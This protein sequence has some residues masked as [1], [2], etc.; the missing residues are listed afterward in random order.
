MS[1]QKLEKLYG[2]LMITGILIRLLHKG[3]NPRLTAGFQSF[4]FCAMNLTALQVVVAQVVV[5]N[6][7]AAGSCRA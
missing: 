1:S 2:P 4:I 3:L 7:D 6:D 5:V